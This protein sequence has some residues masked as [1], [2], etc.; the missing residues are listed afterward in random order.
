M[1]RE[2]G[3]STI[4]CFAFVKKSIIDVHNGFFMRCFPE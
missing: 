4:I 3:C 2:G 1:V